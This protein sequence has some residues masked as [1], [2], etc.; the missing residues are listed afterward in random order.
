MRVILVI[1][2][3]AHHVRAGQAIR[4]FIRQTALKQLP[5]FRQPLALHKFRGDSL[6]R[7][8][9]AVAQ[10][11]RVV[12]RRHQARVGTIIAGKKPFGMGNIACVEC[13]NRAAIRVLHI[14]RWHGKLL[15][16]QQESNH[17]QYSTPCRVMQD[18][19]A[20]NR[21]LS[22]L[23]IFLFTSERKYAII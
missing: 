3:Q 16:S 1:A 20:R 23:I 7:Q 19:R 18:K 11:V 9:M 12:Q 17:F 21:C 4:R 6:P 15:C 13:H 5:A 14:N 22:R 10:K 2:H 8:M